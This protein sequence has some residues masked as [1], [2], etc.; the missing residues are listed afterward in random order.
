VD[1]KD[2]FAK[3]K[4]AFEDNLNHL[5]EKDKQVPRYIVNLS[6]GLFELTEA[7]EAEMLEIRKSI[8]RPSP[9]G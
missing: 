1:T 7:I 5:G 6:R 2:R 3:A 9:M 4:R 8:Q